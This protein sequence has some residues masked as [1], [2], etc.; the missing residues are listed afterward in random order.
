MFFL[1]KAQAKHSAAYAL[2]TNAGGCL[3]YSTFLASA[4]MELPRVGRGVL[5]VLRTWGKCLRLLF[6]QPKT[7]H[8]PRNLCSFQLDCT[9]AFLTVFVVITFF[10]DIYYMVL[11]KGRGAAVRKSNTEDKRK[12][13]ERC[14]KDIYNISIYKRLKKVKQ[15]CGCFHAKK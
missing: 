4:T 14:H 2:I 8:F 11:V 7:V 15:S 10:S 12:Q 6:L 5:F 13:N 9:V 3:K 1:I